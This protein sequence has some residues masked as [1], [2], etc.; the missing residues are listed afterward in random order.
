[1]V[2]LEVLRAGMGGGWL[3]GWVVSMSKDVRKGGGAVLL[4]GKLKWLG[5]ILFM[6]V[7]PSAEPNRLCLTMMR[8]KNPPVMK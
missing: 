8:L 7:A 4:Q 2:Q 3:G 5:S 1:M 6:I